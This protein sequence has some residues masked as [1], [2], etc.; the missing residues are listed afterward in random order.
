MANFYRPNY[1]T[2]QV[3][4]VSATKDMPMPSG[5]MPKMDKYSMKYEENRKIMEVLFNEAQNLLRTMAVMHELEK[6]YMHSLNMQGFKRLH[7]YK[8]RERFEDSMRIQTF[9]IDIHHLKPMIDVDYKQVENADGVPEHMKHWHEKLHY[10]ITRLSEI[11]NEVVM[12]G[13]PYSAG[14]LKMIIRD[15]EDEIKY[16]HRY[17]KFMEDCEY[18]LEH[19]YWYDEKI[20]CE[21]KE[22]ECEEHNRIFK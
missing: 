13:E 6:N 7:R 9:M 22:K 21:Y 4:E 8:A 18:E 20:H 5:Q 12:M 10:A 11:H 3:K 16:V 17:S 1:N 19:L 15:L 2:N 14:I